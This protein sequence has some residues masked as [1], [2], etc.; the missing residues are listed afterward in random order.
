MKSL[1]LHN[2]GVN[3]VGCTVDEGF[4][5]MGELTE[6]EFV[7]SEGIDGLKGMRLRISSAKSFRRSCLAEAQ[8]GH[9]SVR[10]DEKA[11]PFY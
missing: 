10:G 3:V 11:T 5:F 6:R 2:G 1:T 7:L 8:V 4:S 9:C